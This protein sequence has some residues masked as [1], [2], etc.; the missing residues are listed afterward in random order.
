MT[1]EER[2]SERMMEEEED[3]VNDSVRQ[4]G[5]ERERRRW[6]EIDRAGMCEI[7]EGWE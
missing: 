7:D 2:H 6:R 4:R 3:W 5:N 1:G